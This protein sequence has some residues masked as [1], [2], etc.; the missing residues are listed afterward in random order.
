MNPTTS[1]C[2]ANLTFLCGTFG[3][4]RQAIH[5]ARVGGSTKPAAQ[6]PSLAHVAQPEPDRAQGADARK[7]VP[8]E[9]LSPP[10]R[11]SSPS[12][13]LGAFGRF[14]PRSVAA[15]SWSACAGATL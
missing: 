7:G 8:A 11:T 3:V 6:A 12:R 2:T 5:V 1:C 13:P 10:S 4:S 9:E 14:G 15:R